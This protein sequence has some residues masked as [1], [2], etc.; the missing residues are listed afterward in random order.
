MRR[1]STLPSRLQP[2]GLSPPQLSEA[3]T[4]P[5]TKSAKNAPARTALPCRAC[6]F[7]AGR[8]IAPGRQPAAGSAHRRHRRRRTCPP[9]PHATARR[10]SRHRACC[11]RRRPR[12]HADQLADASWLCRPAGGTPCTAYQVRRRYCR[13]PCLICG[14]D[15]ISKEHSELVLVP[16]TAPSQ[17]PADAH[18]RL[19]GSGLVHSGGWMGGKAVGHELHF[20]ACRAVHEQGCR[21]A[22]C[23]RCHAR[24]AVGCLHA[25]PAAA[26]AT[27][28]HHPPAPPPCRF[29]FAQAWAV[30]AALDRSAG[31]GFDPIPCSVGPLFLAV[32]SLGL[33]ASRVTPFETAAA[34]FGFFQARCARCAG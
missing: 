1:D 33:F 16:L 27:P 26:A 31:A 12:R 28:P 14:P 6:Q 11:A 19:S 5:N 34:L 13:H 23:G 17:F 24:R 10:P 7:P 18:L 21:Y 25:S 4:L 2:L 29:Y 30:L 32:Q 8:S 22:R 15:G 3:R 20:S 9:L